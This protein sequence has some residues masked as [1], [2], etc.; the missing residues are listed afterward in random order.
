MTFWEKSCFEDFGPKHEPKMKIFKF[1]KNEC[2]EQKSQKHKSLKL[3]H[4]LMNFA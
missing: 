1:Q 2:I 3:T 4:K